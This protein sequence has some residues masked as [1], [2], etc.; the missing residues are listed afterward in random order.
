[1]IS[2]LFLALFSLFIQRHIVSSQS[3]PYEIRFTSPAPG[4]NAITLQ[5]SGKHGTQVAGASFYRNGQNIANSSCFTAYPTSSSSE[6]RIELQSQECD[7]FF[8][9]GLNGT[10][11]IPA[12]FYACPLRNNSDRTISAQEGDSVFLTCDFPLSPINP[13]HT[14][15][16]KNRGRSDQTTL[17]NTSVLQGYNVTENN[18]QHTE[19][20]CQI[21]PDN[22]CHN[23]SPSFTGPF[24]NIRFIERFAVPKI[25]QDL[26]YT[27]DN[28]G[29][30]VFSVTS[31]GTNL[32]HKWYKDGGLVN[33]TGDSILEISDTSLRVKE[34][35]GSLRIAYVVSNVDYDNTSH[36]MRQAFGVYNVSCG[37]ITEDSMET[38]AVPIM[39]TVIG[40]LIIICLILVLCL[41]II[42]KK[43]KS[44]SEKTVPVEFTRRDGSTVTEGNNDMRC[45]EVGGLQR[46]AEVT[47][48]SEQ[49]DHGCMTC[50]YEESMKPDERLSL[51]AM[52]MVKDCTDESDF[53]KLL[54]EFL[55]KAKYMKKYNN[56]CREL[57]SKM[58]HEV[59]TLME[60]IEPQERDATR[61]IG[62]DGSNE[63]L[64]SDNQLSNDQHDRYKQYQDIR[65]ILQEIAS[66]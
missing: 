55:L 48:S 57:C 46:L 14:T 62:L 11:S 18:P 28:N 31:R 63:H 13:Y 41:Y 9:C 60:E 32:T 66:K 20:V 53:L 33:S 54:L 6:L 10:L 21:K 49:C 52:R 17:Q 2:L 51:F 3:T 43:Y 26:N 30:G 36:S 1:M 50:N 16:I 29:E 19:Y 35:N 39:G 12:A 34:V 61:K 23:G 40:I 47:H 58:I 8:S 22:P 15:W 64:L 59:D 27:M 42:Y 24:I 65:K 44:A 45:D 7:G 37:G 25:T 56:K 4:G 38:L 5:C